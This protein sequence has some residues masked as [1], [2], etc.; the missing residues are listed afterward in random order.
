MPVNHLNETR[1]DRF[2]SL[3]AGFYQLLISLPRRSSITPGKLGTFQLPRGLYIYTGSARRNLRSRIVRHLGREKRLRWHVDYLLQYGIIRLVLIYP[4]HLFTECGLN[5]MALRV[6]NGEFP[7]HR[8]G[9]SDCRCRSHLVRVPK[10]AGF[11][12]VERSICGAA[13]LRMKR[14][15][16]KIGGGSGVIEF[17]WPDLSGE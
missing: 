15:K 12:D 13:E 8:F 17:L 1:S 14:H 7:I 10:G 5:L 3:D 16:P 11:R 2:C 4:L 9:A 6:L